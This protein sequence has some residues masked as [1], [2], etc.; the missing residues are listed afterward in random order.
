MYRIDGLDDVSSFE[1]SGQ[2]YRRPGGQS[3]GLLRA[4]DRVPIR[5][6]SCPPE[7]TRSARIDH[8]VRGAVRRTLI[9]DHLEPVERLIAGSVNDG[10]A[11][12]LLTAQLGDRWA[13]VVP[14]ELNLLYADLKQRGY[15][16]RGQTALFDGQEH[17]GA[18]RV[19]ESGYDPCRRSE[20]DPAGAGHEVQTDPISPGVQREAGVVAV[21][22]A[23]NLYNHRGLVGLRRQDMRFA[24]ERR[25]GCA[26]DLSRGYTVTMNEAFA[27][28]RRVSAA[29]I[30][31]NGALAV[32]KLVAGMVG[33]SYALVADAVESLGDIFSSTIVW[34]GLAIAARPAD[35][36][37]PY[38][39]G[40]A[41][42]LA[43]LIVAIM[44][45]AAGCGIAVAAVHEIRTPH[46]AP[47][48]FT[49][50]V[51]IL[52]VAAKESMYRFASRTGHAIGSTAVVVDA[53]HHRSDA[54]TSAA[55]GVGIT[56]ALVG[57]AGYE[58]AD[59]WAA[60]AA[61]AVI[62]A[63]GFR[64]ARTAVGELMDSSPAT[65]PAD[66]IRATA[67]TIDGARGIEKILI[68]KMGPVWYVDLHLEVDPTMTVERAH[69]VG[70]DVKDAIMAKWPAV[71]DVLVHVEPHKPS[72]PPRRS[73]RG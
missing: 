31:V 33:Q 35:A 63:N 29:G 41:E 17:D 1:T 4:T 51:L 14:I 56:I 8:D 52:V 57:G 15:R 34:G 5:P 72:A 53:W 16:L 48:P 65:A 70:H 67:L 44:L 21:R 13:D 11:I 47:A 55:A 12:E 60:L 71:A 69:G 23:A 54:I 43:A 49:L 42:P 46:H 9:Q 28:G 39:H 22:D 66:E 50:A 37:H 38:G 61:C 7:L 68:R 73:S 6:H 24:A 18:G 3:T 2:E 58:S 59:D 20:L 64:F 40:K 25:T 36:N 19:V 45:L 26:P 62:L 10:D 27:K 30:A 32:A